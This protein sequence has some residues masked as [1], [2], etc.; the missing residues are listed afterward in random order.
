MAIYDI[1]GNVI[2][3]GNGTVD[4]SLLYNFTRWNGKSLVTEGNSLTAHNKWGDY[5]AEFL[6]MTHTNNAM[7]G[8]AIT[9]NP[10]TSIARQSQSPQTHC[11]QLPR[12]G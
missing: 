2:S 9:T 3:S 10:Q 5:L 4:N 8:S 6:G 1:N 12:S 7:S 11:G